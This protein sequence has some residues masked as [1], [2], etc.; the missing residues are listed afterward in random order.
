VVFADFAIDKSPLPPKL[1]AG[2]IRRRL[3]GNAQA[4]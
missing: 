4:S 2:A 3:F 1:A